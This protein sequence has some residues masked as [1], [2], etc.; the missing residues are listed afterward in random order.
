MKAVV[1]RCFQPGEGPSR[2]LLRDYTT[3]PINSLQH[4]P[5]PSPG[6]AQAEAGHRGQE[7]ED[8]AAD[9]EEDRGPQP[10]HRPASR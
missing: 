7:Q 9:R 8:G 6:R 5:G 2:G 4:Y 10:R 3:S 1:H